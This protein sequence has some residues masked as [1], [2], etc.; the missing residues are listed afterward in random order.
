MEID[1]IDEVKCDEQEDDSD[2][3]IQGSRWGRLRVVTSFGLSNAERVQAVQGAE[4]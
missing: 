3:G 1:E 2:E 4:G